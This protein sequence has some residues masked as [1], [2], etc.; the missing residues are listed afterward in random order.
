MIFNKLLS[1]R[2]AITLLELIHTS[3]FCSN[4]EDFKGLV[5]RLNEVIPYD[6]AISGLA[7]TDSYGNVASYK[8]INVNYPA[9]W[10][11]VYTSKNLYDVDSLIKEN[12]TNFRLQRWKDTFKKCLTP[13]KFLSHAEDFGLRDG[14]THGQKNPA[15]NRGSIF[16]VSGNSIEFNNR[17]EMIL[18]LVVP[19]FHQV[20]TRITEQQSRNDISPLSKREIEVLT[21]LRQGKSSWDISMILRISERTVNFH[22]NNIKRKLDVVNRLQAVSV[23]V[24]YRLIDIE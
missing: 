13:K 6:F 3:L 7:K 18:E 19:H 5:V 11:D 2:D 10:L 21:W 12:F 20:I 24:Q 14:F 8:I 17:T 15:G 4:E 23:A 9:E 22:I 1:K 16:T